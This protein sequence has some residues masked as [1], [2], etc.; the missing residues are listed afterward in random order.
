MKV[1]LCITGSLAS[2]ESIKLA[3]ELRRRNFDVKVVASED[4]L[5]IVG[6]NALNFVADYTELNHVELAGIG[7][8]CD[9]VLI[10][11][12]TANTI[13]KIANGISDSRV[14]LIAL[15]A[16]GSGKKVIVAPAMHLG[17]LRSPALQRNLRLLEE[18][19]ISIVEPKI[20]ENKA[21]LA[22]IEEICL[23]VERE[24]SPDNFAG[25][26]VVVT[27]GPT[28]EYIDPIRFISNRSSGRMGL[29][30]A[31]EFWRR[32]AKVVHITSKPSALRLKGFREVEVVSVTDMLQACLKEVRDCDLFVSS[33]A[34]SDFI[35]DKYESKIK[36]HDTF[37][38]RMKAAPKIIHELRKVY[39]GHIIGFKAE[40]GVDE[41][42]LEEI[43]V[44]K[45]ISDN[46]EMVVAN[47]VA[48]RGMG[49]EDTRVLVVTRKNKRWF[50]GSKK[51]V[52]KR[53][54]DLYVEFVAGNG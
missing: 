54:V 10:A 36:T 2:V 14:T 24:N 8:W 9:V 20:E 41:S 47:D 32:K 42:K 51:D 53:I 39:S 48:D 31:L 52:A 29:E 15:T 6:K 46:L 22:G 13:S 50:E 26:K 12:A 17:M 21:K 35:V 4:A 3:R 43:A 16:L 28:Y 19:G 40:T 7:G 1:L 37:T 38:L 33:A 34:P 45:M 27:S 49:T 18:M 11:P 5:K 44:E 23:Y 30:L 25:K